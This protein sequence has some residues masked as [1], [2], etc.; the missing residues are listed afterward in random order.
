MHIP[1]QTLPN[2]K[3]EI[4]VF[5]AKEHIGFLVLILLALLAF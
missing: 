5:T 1:S 4:E 2:P 3:Y